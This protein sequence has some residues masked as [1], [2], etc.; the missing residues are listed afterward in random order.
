MTPRAI[1][2]TNPLT[3]VMIAVSNGNGAS[4]GEVGPIHHEQYAVDLTKAFASRSLMEWGPPSSESV[5]Q[6][7]GLV[8]DHA[9][10]CFR[11]KELTRGETETTR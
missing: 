10:F 4:G 2:S 3:K 8:N 11:Y 7:V 6:S 1:Y 5:M 9:R